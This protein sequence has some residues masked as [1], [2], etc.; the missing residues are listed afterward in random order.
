MNIEDGA[1]GSEIIMDGAKKFV[2]K[3]QTEYR[4]KLNKLSDYELIE[5]LE[6]VIS[7]D[8][9]FPDERI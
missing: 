5:R 3:H 6:E 7:T 1:T 4:N 8:V 2:E 9:E